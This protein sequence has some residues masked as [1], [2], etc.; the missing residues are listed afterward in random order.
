MFFL[1]TIALVISDIGNSTITALETLAFISTIIAAGVFAMAVID[2][3]I[4]MR[5]Y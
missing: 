2:A 3:K 4:K 5:R 1:E